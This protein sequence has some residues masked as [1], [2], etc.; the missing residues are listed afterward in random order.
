MKPDFDPLTD[1]WNGQTH[2]DGFDD[3]HATFCM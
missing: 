1:L 2:L 3:N